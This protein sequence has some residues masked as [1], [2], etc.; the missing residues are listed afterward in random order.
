MI[1][2]MPNTPTVYTH[3]ISQSVNP[4]FHCENDEESRKTTTRVRHAI[5][6]DENVQCNV[7]GM[8]SVVRSFGKIPLEHGRK[9][10]TRSIDRDP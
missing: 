9:S 10:A 4:R 7:I 5:F 2:R 1:K 8:M 6:R 3:R